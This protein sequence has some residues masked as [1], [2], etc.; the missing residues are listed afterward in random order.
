MAAEA[1]VRRADAAV[2]SERFTCAKLSKVI[3]LPYHTVL[4]LT[5]SHRAVHSTELY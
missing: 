4:T 3:T 1:A 5:Y 2:Y